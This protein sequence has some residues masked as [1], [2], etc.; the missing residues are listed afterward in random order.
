[1]IQKANKNLRMLKQ[2]IGFLGMGLSLPL[3]GQVQTLPY[4]PEEQDSVSII[5]DASQGNG[6]LKGASVVYAHTGVI[7]SLSTSQNNWLHIV[8]NWGTDDARVRMRNLG[9]DKHLLR[10][11]MKNFYTL[12]GAF[13][14]GE[15][16][17][18]MAFVFRNLSGSLVG[19][20][21]EGGDI[22][23]KI[24]NGNFQT[25][26]FKPSG[27]VIS[28]NNTSLNLDIRSSEQA[29]KITLYQNG[30]AIDSAENS[31]SLIFV[32]PTL[33]T[34]NNIFIAQGFN[35]LVYS[36]DTFTYILNPSV[37]Y[38]APPVAIEQ[39]YN[40]IN[41]STA[42]FALYAPNKKYAYLIGDF[43][44]W[45]PNADY[46][47][48]FSPSQSL[49]WIEVKGLQKNQSYGYQYFVDG[50]IR[51][52]DP[53]SVLLLHEG[54]DPYISA[55]N[56]PN[57]KPYPKGKTNGYVSVIKHAKNPYLWKH[58]S[59]KRP[60]KSQLNIYE[61]LV[62]DFVSTQRYQTLIDSIPYFKKLG[63]NA[64]EL[65]PVNEFEGNLSWGYNVA[66]HMA[67]DKYYG[68]PEAFQAFIDSCHAAGI[69]VILD[70]VFNHAFSQAAIC[71]LYWNSADFKPA[72]NN[73][74]VNT[75]AKHP[76]NVGYD[77]NHES[78]ATKYY[79]KRITQFLVNEYHIDGFRF[80][81]S[82]GFTQKNT[83]S[84][85]GA[86]GQYDAS[87]V[88]IW[89]D[90][91]Q[92]LK[93]VDSGLYIILEHFADNSEEKE[94]SD[95]GMMFWGNANHAFNESTM[96]YASNSDVTWGVSSKARGWKDLSLVGYAESHDEERLV[97]KNGQFGN[98]SGNYQIK[99]KRLSIY[100][101]V[102]AQVFLLSVP[103]PKMLWQFGEM[104]YD[105]SIN[106]CGNGTINNDC[107]TDSKPIRWDYYNDPDRK[108]IWR[109][110]AAMTY[111]RNTYPSFAN[112]QTWNLLGNGYS[113]RV[114]I[115]DPAIKA[116]VAANFNVVENN[117]ALVFSDT[118]TWYEYLTGD[119]LR[120][121]ANNLSLLFK[122]GEARVYLNKKVI[123]PYP[124]KVDWILG[125]TSWDFSAELGLYPN[126]VHDQLTLEGVQSGQE[127]W[128]Y[129]AMGRTVKQTKIG[130]TP[131]IPV[132]DLAEGWYFIAVHH[133]GGI[134]KGRFFKQ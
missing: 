5:Y 39:G 120:V 130:E 54:D 116:V 86:W 27:T 69:A 15:K 90:Y 61:L 72:A 105:Y 85:V 6:A 13:A 28:G 20:S 50:S 118:G 65:M 58:D 49:W 17:I 34:G 31:D 131:V 102:P 4:F 76:F 45:L 1:M 12:G 71:Q 97:Y 70:A 24:G 96:G 83:G 79:F 9:G 41:D 128:V 29:Q 44:Q 66:N 87:R 22:F 121:S 123:N 48:H 38:K 60:D 19:R 43:N 67:L 115:E 23:Y 63:I 21:A 46:F 25:A 78:S 119:S 75:D 110:T 18:S 106:Y 42:I 84:D 95:A 91:Y 126:P 14:N 111:L 55:Q 127:V 93:N 99:N 68:T 81:L 100:R 113:K 2:F 8:G 107:R 52:H 89:K 77:L 109:A 133:E 92:H 64:I 3:I 108:V 80:D 74:W 88:A 129:D 112:P 40:E 47:M 16:I 56:F 82:K 117:L 104:G 53:F 132:A 7:T 10:I 35:G 122:P 103:G 37:Q 134:Y 32:N 33:V 73:P 57:L 26:F 36:R 30:V 125:S 11:H 62:R 114:V 59:F 51:V 101:S 94:L 124:Q 98:A